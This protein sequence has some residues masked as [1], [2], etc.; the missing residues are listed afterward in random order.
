MP[1]DTVTQTF[2]VSILLCVVCSVLVSGVAVALRPAQRVNR[3]RFMKTNVLIAAGLH[4]PRM[5]ADQIEQ[6]FEER[7]V[8][9]IID[10][11]TGEFTDAVDPEV[12]DQRAAERDPALSRSIPSREDIAGVRRREKYS[13]VYLVRDDE[14]EIAEIVLPIRGYG[15]WSTL[16]G[17][18]AID[19]R[20]LRESPE[21]AEIQ[22]L[23]YYEHAET[24]GL[25]GEVDNEQWKA[26]W[27][28]KR[29][30]DQ[31][32]NVAIR[33]IKGT[34]PE[35]HPREEFMVDG[36]AGATITANGV[37]NMLRYWLGEN[38]FLPFLRSV[39]EDPEVL[40]RAVE[41]A[42]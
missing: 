4:R 25:G 42:E 2:K 19:A 39:H 27:V 9:R 15:L 26:Q 12:Y 33:V 22:G 17:F 41:T 38:G 1:R 11:D 3:E 30:F 13:Y 29:A 35:D 40:E 24:P 36:L 34:V 37:T 31:E 6:M 20:G 23:T 8:E 10:L 28:G 21:V 16:R 18:I 7:V 5:T 14:G 32:W